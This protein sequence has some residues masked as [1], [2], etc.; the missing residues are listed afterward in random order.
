VQADLLTTTKAKR[1]NFMKVIILIQMVWCG[2]APYIVF[3]KDSIVF[4]FKEEYGFTHEQLKSHVITHK[5]TEK[6][7]TRFKFN[8]NI[9]HAREELIEPDLYEQNHLVFLRCRVT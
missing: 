6:K 5:I 7:K 3:C 2:F 4:A 1:L 8:T 9:Q